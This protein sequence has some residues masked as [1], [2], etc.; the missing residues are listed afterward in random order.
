[1][2]ST[3]YSPHPRWMLVR[4]SIWS[5]IRR[6]ERSSSGDEEMV[7]FGVIITWMRPPARPCQSCAN[8]SA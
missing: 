2:T 3:S 6:L 8:S 7:M 4:R 1:M 5:A